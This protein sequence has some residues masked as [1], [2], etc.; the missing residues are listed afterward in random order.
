MS[1]VLNRAVVALTAVAVA[2][3]TALAG[4][5]AQAVATSVT[6]V[7]PGD[8]ILVPGTVSGTTGTAKADFLAEGIH[9]KT[10]NQTDAAR[11][12]WKT[13]V[14]LA[15]VHAVEYCLLYTSD[16]ADE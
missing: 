2:G 11:G 4:A 8:L 7:R 14:K 12:Y 3:G 16:A 1:H 13:N 15:D 6:Q 9:L 5:P 10:T